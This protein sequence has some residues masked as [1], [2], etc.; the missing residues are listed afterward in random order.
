M[1]NTENFVRSVLTG[2]IPQ[3]IIPSELLSDIARYRSLRKTVETNR[4]QMKRSRTWSSIKIFLFTGILISLLSFL[5]Y[6]RGDLSAPLFFTG[7]SVILCC[8][9]FRAII[10]AE[11]ISDAYYQS[12]EVADLDLVTAR[13][14]PVRREVT[15]LWSQLRQILPPAE[16]A[17]CVSLT[18]YQICAD[19]A[20][21]RQAALIKEIQSAGQDTP[22]STDDDACQEK[23]QFK[24]LYDSCKRLGL[25]SW[26][27]GRYFASAI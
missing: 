7:S 26:G 25:V 20:L 4:R 15:D 12:R 5:I 19:K 27:Y 11:S 21:R 6:L 14:K 2:T 24:T 17:G 3:E 8:G 18:D 13:L 10:R 16:L 9:G 23:A 1:G 22:I